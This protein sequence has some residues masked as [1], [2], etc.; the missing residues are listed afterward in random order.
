M[1]PFLKFKNALESHGGRLRQSGSEFRFNC[2][3]HGGDSES[4]KIEV[5]SGGALLICCHSKGCSAE[6]I[7]AAVGLKPADLFPTPRTKLKT[8]RE[9]IDGREQTVHES[10][11][12]AE[13][14][15][16][17]GI[18]EQARK[19]GWQFQQRPAD[20]RF[21][22]R[23]AA[24]EVLFYVA[25]WQTPGRPDGTTKEVRP[26]RP[27]A[28]GWIIRGLPPKTKRPVYNL[29]AILA[30]SPEVEIFVAEGEKAADS[31]QAA[32]ILSTTS[33]GGAGKAAA[34]DWQ[35]LAG[36]TVCILPD[37]DDRGEDYAAEVL[38]LL[39]K[40]GATVRVCRLADDWPSL[41]RK[42]DSAEWLA[43]RAGESGEQLLA[44]LQQLPDCSAEILAKHP[45]IGR[46]VKPADVRAVD[47]APEHEAPGLPVVRFDFDEMRAADSVICELGK[48]PDIFRT[49]GGLVQLLATDDGPRPHALNSASLRE[50]ISSAVVLVDKTQGAQTRPPK[51]LTDAIAA[52]PDWFGVRRL[53]GIMNSPALRSDGT[54]IRQAGWDEASGLFCEFS[55]DE[56][57]AIP[58]APGRGDAVEALEQL[59]AVVA[60]FP[61]ASGADRSGWLALVLSVIGRQMIGGPCPAFA[62]DAPARGSGKT[63]LADAA[64][65]IVGNKP[66]ARTAW[67]TDEAEARKRLS[68]LLFQTAPPGLVLFDNCSQRIGGDSIE[69]I[70]TGDVWADRLLGSSTIREV[71]ISTVFAFSGNNLRFSTDAVRRTVRVRLE[72]REQNPE[73]REN[74]AV[75]DLRGHV[76]ERRR[77]LY[78][79]GLVAL[80]AFAAAGFPD[81]QTLPNW[82]SFEAWSKVVRGVLVWCGF[83]DPAESRKLL[84]EDAD[85]DLERLEPFMTALDSIDPGGL[86]MTG[87]E[88]LELVRGAGSE[89]FA[90]LRMA[91]ESLCGRQIEAI[92]SRKLGAALKQVRGRVVNGQAL[93]MK[94]SN[95]RRTWFLRSFS[96]S[97]DENRASGRQGLHP[98]ATR[99]IVFQD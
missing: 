72:P 20:R 21:E 47:E 16:A 53:R 26:I 62:H 15:A 55:P 45:G 64:G 99:E 6:Q 56:W 30:A 73:D 23:N 31:L 82:G 35:P 60:D 42:G 18:A 97:F 11:E 98:P 27:A 3:A 91:I 86:G 36:R 84:R 4:A 33:E 81:A 65:I 32:G 10:A 93:E 50:L 37:R 17:Y 90:P 34:S 19:G 57:P 74:F 87:E 5:G 83:A 69:A 7:A 1:N 2:P 95:S 96:P 13:L 78:S 29:P 88:L 89:P 12:A 52:R 9:L 67:P 25:R 49:E 59:A 92:D 39:R 71:P 38:Q 24:G 85:S 8:R 79:A 44:R 28:S 43:E 14:A 61:F 76:R 22:Y 46:R 75:A 68:A 77:E 54:L 66:P 94:K 80:S 48:R 58:E 40:I 51:W 70:L 41:P 63:L